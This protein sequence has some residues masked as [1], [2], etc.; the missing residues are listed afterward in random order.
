MA[1]NEKMLQAQINQIYE[2]AGA[3]IAKENK[4]GVSLNALDPSQQQ[5][6]YRLLGKM[7]LSNNG[8]DEND[9]QETIRLEEI[10]SLKNRKTIIVLYFSEETLAASKLSKKYGPSVNFKT[11]EIHKNGS[12]NF[13]DKI[14]VNTK[15]IACG[16]GLP[17][18]NSI[19]S[20][21]G[22]R[23]SMGNLAKAISENMVKGQTKIKIALHSCDAG[24][25]GKGNVT[26]HT[27]SIAGHLHAQLV[28]L[29]I[30]PT[31]SA[32][33]LSSKIDDYGRKRTIGNNDMSR[34]E[35]AIHESLISNLENKILLYK[36]KKEI[37]LLKKSLPNP[38]IRGDGLSNEEIAKSSACIIDPRKKTASDDEL[39]AMYL[40][41]TGICF[42]EIN[43]KIGS[44]VVLEYNPENPCVPKITYPYGSPSQNLSEREFDSFS[45]NTHVTAFSK[46]IY[47]DLKKNSVA[48]RAAWIEIF[49]E[50]E[51]GAAF[52]NLQ[53]PEQDQLK[54][55]KELIC[56]TME[57]PFPEAI[58][59]I[60]KKHQKPTNTALMELCYKNEE[61]K[62]RQQERVVIV[63]DRAK[64]M[65]T[66]IQKDQLALNQQENLGSVIVEQHSAG[67]TS[68]L[69]QPSAANVSF[70]PPQQQQALREPAH[71]AYNGK[72][73]PST[74]YNGSK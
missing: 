61:I 56:M 4:N 44:K 18:G 28:H 7:V 37:S 65:K 46:K 73:Y 48:A 20:S 8:F 70:F 6:L 29:K 66:A 52:K 63:F 27:N 9:I 67:K 15:I 21:S 53:Q 14:N 1:G 57:L 69:Q 32:K 19:A 68:S 43:K 26:D 34:E 25:E 39:L 42:F 22:Q 71:T 74:S 3:L 30:E 12:V 38:I 2:K 36:I 35:N 5:H 16:H 33:L 64:G 45:G 50:F 72:P 17:G 40:L 47:G 41:G 13:Q 24:S 23:L 31:I 58:E 62:R 59:H 60:L 51:D 49:K 55:D 10:A 11:V 54:Q